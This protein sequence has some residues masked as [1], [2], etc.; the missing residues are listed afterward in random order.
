MAEIPN[1][2]KKANNLINTDDLKVVYR[3]FV[4]NW[5]FFLIIPVAL[6]CL[7]FFYAHRM[8][9]MYA[10]STQILLKSNDTYNYQDRIYQSIGYMGVY[11]D[12]TNQKRILSSYDLIEKALDKLDF[13][14][15]YFIKGRLKTTELYNSMPF[16][17]NIDVVNSSLEGIPINFVI[18]NVDTYRLEY[19]LDGV[20]FVRTHHFEQ[21]EVNEDYIIQ[22]ERRPEL[23]KRSEKRLN[24]LKY[25]IIVHSKGSLISKIRKSL[26]IENVEYTTIL[27]IQ[28]AD[29]IPARAKMFLDTLSKVYIDYSEETEDTIHART[30]FHIGNQI[31]T[32]KV[33]LDTLETDL[34]NYRKDSSILDL[35]KE[36]NEFFEQWVSFDAQRRT[37]VL[38]LQSIDNLEKY[39]QRTKDHNLIPPSSYVP[40]KDDFLQRSLEELY[41]MQI[42]RNNATL[43]IKPT[44][45]QMHQIDSLILT[46]KKDILRYL[47]DTRQALVEKRQAVEKQLSQYAGLIKKVPRKERD[48]LSIQRE[49]Q[50]NEKLYLFLLEKQANTEIAK[51]GITPQV[52]IIEK[53]RSVGKVGPNKNK[54][55]YIFILVGVVIAIL[56]AFIRYLY[57]DKI[58][59]L[60]DLR[61]LTSLPILSG[62]PNHKE[63]DSEKLVIAARPKAQITEAFRHLRTNLS[64]L[65]STSDSKVILVSSIFPGEGK[66]FLSSNLAMVLAKSQKKTLL[67]DLDLHKPKVHQSFD[68]NNDNG[69]S[70]Y[71]IGKKSIEEIT[72]ELPEES[73][74][75]ILSGPVPP[76]PSELM[77][78]QKLKELIEYGR[79]NYEV[80][81]LDTPP[82]GLISDAMV[83]LDKVDVGIFVMNTNV[84]NRRGVEFLEEIV[85]KSKVNSAG[86]V[87]NGIKTRKWNRFRLGYGYGYGY[88]YG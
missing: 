85:A 73:A 1:Q 76:N 7:A 42:Q 51:A 47:N 62:I 32:L 58:E 41:T 26:S 57:F 67:V 75:L 10:A 13:K 36:S 16:K 74:H 84:A 77:L 9:D 27:Q 70:S 2:K 61:D 17:V 63:I 6:F 38:Q 5:H 53:A 11:G 31:D 12:I 4:K 22:T 83:L 65:N 14:V 79:K 23:S 68:L 44:H 8:T 28:L 55:Y 24:Q 72:K 86:L 45:A 54:I 30:L 21:R 29:H 39:I 15:S 64:Y 60:Q 56:I 66:T 18:E 52:K 59:K 25:E 35:G 43:D 71:L 20:P 3:V 48:M 40:D 87:L 34:E 49:K 33:R 81:I 69:V 78:S 19:E 46:L 50:V 88:G 37:L 82:I 80:V